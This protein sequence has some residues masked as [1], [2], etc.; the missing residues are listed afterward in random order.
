LKPELLTTEPLD[1]LKLVEN[2]I[3]EILQSPEVSCTGADG[4]ASLQMVIG[5]HVSDME[6][7]IPVALPLSSNYD[8]LTI[9]FT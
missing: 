2:A 4:L 8:D 3:K 9:N 6:G 7:N 1:P 5:F